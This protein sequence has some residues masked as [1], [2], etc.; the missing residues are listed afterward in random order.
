MIANTCFCK[1]KEICADKNSTE[2]MRHR[3]IYA[4]FKLQ[5]SDKGSC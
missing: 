1:L 3:N 5:K 4:E 2:C